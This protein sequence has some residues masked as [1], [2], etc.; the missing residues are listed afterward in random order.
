MSKDTIDWSGVAR[1]RREAKIDAVV[2]AVFR[3]LYGSGDWADCYMLREADRASP[4]RAELEA[5]RS[6]WRLRHGPR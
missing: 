5:I 4:T 3:S 2:R 1:R 6:S